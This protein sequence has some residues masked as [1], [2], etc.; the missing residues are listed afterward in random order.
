MEGLKTMTPVMEKSSLI[1]EV[2]SLLYK[3]YEQEK[4]LP[5]G[6]ARDASLGVVF[7]LLREVSEIEERL[8]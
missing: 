2:K 1:E 6:E 8:R 7:R 4:Q 5:N 3:E